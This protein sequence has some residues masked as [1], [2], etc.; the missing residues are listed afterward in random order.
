[1]GG[2]GTR[3]CSRATA[4]VAGGSRRCLHTRNDQRGTEQTTRWRCGVKPGHGSRPDG[5]IALLAE[6]FND[7]GA[8]Q[9]E[10]V[11]PMGKPP[12]GQ[13]KQLAALGIQPR[14]AAGGKTRGEAHPHRRM[15]CVGE[16]TGCLGAM[17]RRHTIHRRRLGPTKRVV[18]TGIE[19]D[20]QNVI[21]RGHRF[22]DGDP[23]TVPTSLNSPMQGCW[24]AETW[25]NQGLQVYANGSPERGLKMLQMAHQLLPKSGVVLL[26]LGFLKTAV[27]NATAAARCY[28]MALEDPEAQ[29]SASKNL[30]FLELTRGNP[31]AAG[32]CITNVLA[33]RS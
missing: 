32:P 30:G 4:A 25:N 12:M 5:E 8:L 3:W 15:G 13:T 19:A 17:E 16:I 1:M 7:V 14:L 10:G 2:D 26:N 33:I 20:Q 21:R 27:G 24:D 28:T 22:H 23:H 18:P 9:H 31:S 29:A 6:P 11:I